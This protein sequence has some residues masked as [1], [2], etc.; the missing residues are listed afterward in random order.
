MD[1]QVKSKFE[2]FYEP[3]FLLAVVGILAITAVVVVSI[4]RDRFVNPWQK[5]VSIIGQGKVSYQPD[6]A[7]V[8]LGIAIDKAPTADSAL[9][10]LNGKATRI[11]AALDGLGIKK[12]DI[13]TEAYA[14]NPQ[15]DYVEGVSRIAGYGASQKLS[16]K[17]S[18]II[19]NADKVSQVVST[20]GSA[21]ANE[22]MGIEFTVSNMND[23][24]QQAKILAIGD[25]KK[26]SEGLAR[27][28]GVKLGKVE[29]W[30][31]NIL[32]APDYRVSNAGFGGAEA[33][34]AKAAIAVPQ[35]PAGTQEIIVEVGLTY[36][37]K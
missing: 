14:L 11:I 33:L 35:V 16:I 12:D 28:A 22:V 1:E 5:Q 19:N 36:E 9:A 2:K 23:L 17:V 32:Q 34:S 10:Q 25:A 20:A 37:V 15:Y 29:N 27:A 18:D 6:V 7:T 3:K 26:K 30:Y 8:T 13:K 24:K 31:E 21:T 4:L